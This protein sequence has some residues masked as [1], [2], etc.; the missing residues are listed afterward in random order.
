MP[1]KKLLTLSDRAAEL[2]PQLARYH[3]Q[4]ALVSRLIEDEA[5]RRDR[6]ATIEQ[7]DLESLRTVAR[8]LLQ[9]VETLKRPGQVPGA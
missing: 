7:G 3:D 1:K 5:A 9:E 2:L 4:G 6:A 8:E